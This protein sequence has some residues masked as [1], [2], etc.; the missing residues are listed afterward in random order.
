MEAGTGGCVSCALPLFSVFFC[1]SRAARSWT[2]PEASGGRTPVHRWPAATSRRGQQ[3]RRPPDCDSQEA[4]GTGVS[5]SRAARD[6]TPG[7]Q[8]TTSHP[9]AGGHSPPAL[10]AS[11]P[12]RSTYRD[13][14]PLS[15]LLP[16]RPA[17]A[18]TTALSRGVAGHT[19]TPRRVRASSAVAAPWAVSGMAR[20]TANLLGG[21]PC[22]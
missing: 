17:M 10:L 6:V 15:L 8:L 21:P 14:D 7:D 2:T 22:A 19:V 3:Q 9:P 5:I 12:P 11:E 1:L 18:D 13:T 20:V 16:P 4:T